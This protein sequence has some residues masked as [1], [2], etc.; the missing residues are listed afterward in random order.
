MRRDA[1]F[2]KSETA[3]WKKIIEVSGAKADGA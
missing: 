2:I 1:A 3:K